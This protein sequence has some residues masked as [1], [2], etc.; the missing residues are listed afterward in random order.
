MGRIHDEMQKYAEDFAE[1]SWEVF[2]IPSPPE[3]LTKRQ[4]FKLEEFFQKEHRRFP[5]TEDEFQTWL[6]H[7]W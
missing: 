3:N 7:N 6:R 1:G 2:G 4:R 5:L